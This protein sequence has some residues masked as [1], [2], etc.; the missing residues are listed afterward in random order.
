[1]KL[2]I[3]TPFNVEWL[4]KAK[5][6]L[7]CSKARGDYSF[8]TCTKWMKVGFDLQQ[9]SHI[10]QNLFKLTKKINDERFCYAPQVRDT[11]NLYVFFQFR[12][13]GYIFPFAIYCLLTSVH[14]SQ[15]CLAFINTIKKPTYYC[16][17]LGFI[18]LPTYNLFFNIRVWISPWNTHRSA[19]RLCV[20][21]RC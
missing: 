13:W 17:V 18:N 12:T 4:P 10:I 3:S 15:F 21:R 20:A 14:C 8:S 2:A 1:M 9:T 19:F 16:S 11:L 6:L 7:I 5:N